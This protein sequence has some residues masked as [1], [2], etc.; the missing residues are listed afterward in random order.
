VL[1]D[2]TL[3]VLQMYSLTVP[4]IDAVP[5]DMEQVEWSGK[6]PGH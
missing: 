1:L 4:D 3:Q 6:F 5:L 2:T